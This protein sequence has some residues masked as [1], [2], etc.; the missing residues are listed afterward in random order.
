MLVAKCMIPEKC[1][2]SYKYNGVLRDRIEGELLTLD[3]GVMNLEVKRQSCVI[4]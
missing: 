2:L 4:V 1:W 3:F